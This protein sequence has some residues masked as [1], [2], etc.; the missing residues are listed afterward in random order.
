MAKKL[1]TSSRA[2]NAPLSP[3][4]KFV[5]LLQL[6][7]KRGLDVFELHIGQPDLKT[8]SQILNK[9][10]NFNEKIIRYTPS[11]G[12]PEV[13]SAWKKYFK[14]FGIN[15]DESEIIVTV[16]GSEAIFFALSTACDPG[17][18]VIVFEPFYTNYNS[19]RAIAGVK[20]VPVRTLVNTGFHLPEKN[21]IEKKISRKTK[22]ILVCNPSN[23]TGTVYSKKELQMIIDIAQKHNLFILADEVYR[24]FVYDNEKHYSIM[25]FPKARSRAVILDSVSKRFSACGLRI[26]CLA[27]KNKDIIAGATKFAQARLSSPMVEQLATVPLLL[28]S[29]TYTRKIVKEYK[30]RRDAVF[31]GLQKISGV[32]C[33]KPKGAFYITVKLPVKN[34]ENFTKW[35]LTRFSYKNKTVMLAPAAGFYASKGLGK[36]EVRIAFVLSAP[37]MK[38]AMNVLKIALKKYKE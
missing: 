2:I 1:K 35:L 11:N 7:K 27:S 31:E 29:K 37:K 28:N 25:D 20:L 30:K 26:G 36:D 8:P 38:E 33:L 18:E 23:P 22:A 34:A 16:A 5:P 3:I 21:I 17:D 10:K 15:F 13:Q 24:E 6:A 32:Q 19:F 12:I 14:G 4:R 9:I